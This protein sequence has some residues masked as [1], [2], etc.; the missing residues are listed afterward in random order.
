MHRRPL[1]ALLDRYLGLHPDEAEVVDRMRAFVSAHRDCF[2]RSCVPGHVTGS[3]WLLS[4]DRRSV[5]LTHHRKLGRWLQLGGHADGDPDPLRVALREAREESGLPDVVPLAPGTGAVVPLDVDIHEIPARAGEPA[6]L[7]H[8]VRFL[9]VA[10]AGAAIAIGPESN[11]LRWVAR[12][13]LQAYTREKS[14]LRME[15]KAR[16]LLAGLLD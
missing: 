11:D 4:A 9:L 1:L 13:R 15:W 5:L 14:Q 7:H 16:A 2:E 12:D 3:A 8:D 10:P 6:H